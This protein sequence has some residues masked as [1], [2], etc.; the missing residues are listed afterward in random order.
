MQSE[1]A[2]IEALLLEIRGE[3]RAS[4]AATLTMEMAAER[5]SVSVDT[6]KRMITRNE[7]STVT[8]GKRQMIPASE[9]IRV[10]TPQESRGAPAGR[11]K[12]VVLPSLSKTRR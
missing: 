1:A 2:R 3:L 8:I 7:L 10:S 4:N 11:F 6:V 9:I 12:P 5:L